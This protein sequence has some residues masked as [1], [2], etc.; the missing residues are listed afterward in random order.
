[1]SVPYTACIMV[2]SQCKEIRYPKDPTSKT[3]MLMTQ[4]N[5][6]WSTILRR[7]P[8][9][10]ATLISG[11]SMSSSEAIRPSIRCGT[12]RRCPM[13]LMWYRRM[14]RN[15]VS[16]FGFNQWISDRGGCP[17]ATGSTCVHERK[18]FRENAW[19]LAV[20]RHIHAKSW[21]VL[22]VCFCRC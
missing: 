19:C 21:R 15:N 8:G 16:V 9:P 4:S 18:R 2:S 10:F 22:S 11:P 14:S 1:M 3:P 20:Y 13:E 6:S 17:K 7:P 12:H 5:F